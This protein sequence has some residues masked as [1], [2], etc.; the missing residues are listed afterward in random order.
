M[1][2]SNMSLESPR[3]RNVVQS[4]QTDR[5]FG[6][7]QRQ[8]PPKAIYDPFPSVVS[9]LRRVDELSLHDGC[10]NTID[11][12]PD[13]RALISGSDDCTVG[14]WLP[15]TSK[16]NNPYRVAMRIAT[17]HR[18]NIFC[19]KFV[20]TSNLREVV[21][22]AADG[23]LR[24]FPVEDQPASYIV[25]YRQV[26]EADDYRSM[27]FHLEFLAHSPTNVLACSQDGTLHLYDLRRRHECQLI[28]S[29]ESELR[30]SRMGVPTFCLHPNNSN[31]VLVAGGDMYARYMDLR[32]TSDVVRRF[33]PDDLARSKNVRGSSITGLC[34]SP[35]GDEFALNATGHGVYVIRMRE[36]ENRQQVGPKTDTACHAYDVILAG[37]RNT[38][39]FLK[40][41]RY[42]GGP[43]GEFI[44]TG[45]DCG[46]IMIWNR[47]SCR[48]VAMLHGDGDVVNMISPHP[49]LPVLASCGIEN[50]IKLFA[51]DYDNTENE[52]DVEAITHDKIE[53]LLEL[54]L[55]Q[56]KR[57]R[58]STHYLN[59][60]QEALPTLRRAKPDGCDVYP[61]Y[62]A[63]LQLLLQQQQQQKGEDDGENVGCDY[64]HACSEIK[65]RGNEYFK[66]GSLRRALSKYTK[67]IRY[68]EVAVKNN[69]NKYCDDDSSF[70]P[71]RLGIYLNAA[72]CAIRLERYFDGQRYCTFAIA[73]DSSNP[74]A[75]Y[76]RA[77]CGLNMGDLSCASKDIDRACELAPEDE[78]VKALKVE[79]KHELDA[80]NK[81]DKER[82]AKMFD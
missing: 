79:I 32:N 14:V 13:G 56:M 29:T 61:S 31:M 2:F 53:G 75:F 22:C 4:L 28:Y 71:L 64:A 34:F 3:H 30:P 36:E 69:E 27:M 57:D 78:D 5:Y 38:Q 9:R 73:V 21:S 76:R 23:E 33:K 58:E 66:E 51:P 20:P 52:E 39:T 37:H 81:R 10:V 47:W 77:L 63:D 11:W 42:C 18:H 49:H 82:F 60:F 15:D 41:V 8:C 7:V 45:S 50:T 17:G 12:S 24:H 1:D 62:P 59:Y 19:A 43:N 48:V 80:V 68:A 74:K 44:T 35:A 46:N 6:R 40:G 67:A 26:D 65:R 25:N 72:L 55:Q 16:K 70:D 54:N